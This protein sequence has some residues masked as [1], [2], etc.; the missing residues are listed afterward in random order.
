VDKGKRPNE[1]YERYQDAKPYL[2][3]RI[4]E[5]CSF[6]EYPIFH[7]S[8]VEHK[9]A[10]SLGGDELAWGNLLLSCKYCNSRKGVQVAAGEKGKYLWPDEEDTF[11]VYSYKNGIPKI[12]YEYLKRFDDAYR[13][14]AEKLFC[15]VR[16][17]YV[18][19]SAKDKD[20]RCIKRGEA[21]NTATESLQSWL[22]IKDS[23]D[24]EICLG[25]I[26]KLALASGFFS[27]WM[28]VF[29]EHPE[30]QREF[31]KDFVGTREEYFQDIL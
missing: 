29:K 4:G 11:H 30:V 12:N 26:R 7:I 22:R 14:R 2:I 31:V 21:Y 10:K 28:E 23:E 18:P 16:L 8:E 27:V 25:M 15:L 9:E 13:D 1:E 5:Y 17:D 20:R 3:K 6:C 19:Q 24:K